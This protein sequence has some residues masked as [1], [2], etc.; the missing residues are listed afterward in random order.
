M[1]RWPYVALPVYWITLATLTHYP[2]VRI[3]GEIPSS[4]KVVHFGAFG[5]LAFLWWQLVAVRG[6]LAGSTVWIAAALL[7]AYAALD[8]Y[9]QQF[10][11]RYTDLADGVAN[12]A[13][14]ACVLI[15]LE[16]RR[17]HAARRA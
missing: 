5:L 9:T 1:S 6:R 3:P 17:R 10:V 7:I 8:E 16:L 2:R 13:G 15:A 14:I 12:T 4:D 11:G